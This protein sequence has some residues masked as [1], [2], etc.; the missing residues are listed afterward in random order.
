MVSELIQ[1]DHVGSLQTSVL[2]QKKDTRL[3]H[4]T[5]YLDYSDHSFKVPG[6]FG[7]LEPRQVSFWP[8]NYQKDFFAGAENLSKHFLDIFYPNSKVSSQL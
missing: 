6:G 3:A 1:G 2:D 7:P 4:E 5:S 8:L